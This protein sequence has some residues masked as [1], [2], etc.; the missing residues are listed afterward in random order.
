MTSGKAVCPISINL[1]PKTLES[2][3]FVPFV[4]DQLN[5]F[6][7]SPRLLEFELTETSLLSAK[8]NVLTS[9]NQLKSLGIKITL[10]DFGTNSTSFEYLRNF[11]VNKLKIDPIFISGLECDNHKDKTIVSSMIYLG[12]GLDLDIVAE[13]VEKYEQ[14]HFLKQQECSLM[15]GY[16]FSEPI[17]VE[18]DRKSVV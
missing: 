5:K 17:P 13:G 3:S 7:I 4:E 6:S 10:D 11:E 15:Q 14:F 16:L 18:E 8:K 9:L 12:K 1:S 2:P